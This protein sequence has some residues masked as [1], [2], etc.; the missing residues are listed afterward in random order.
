[1][2][3]RRTFGAECRGQFDTQEGVRREW[4]RLVPGRLD[5]L[6]IAFGVRRG[7]PAS[8][9]LDDGM[10]KRR[11][12]AMDADRDQYTRAVV[13]IHVVAH[14]SDTLPVGKEWGRHFKIS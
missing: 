1:M 14:R 4:C 6:P 10:D 7:E 8:P 2:R 3:D 12:A 13:D 9:A 5:G 11:T